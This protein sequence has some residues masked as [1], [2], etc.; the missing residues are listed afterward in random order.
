MSSILAV[1]VLVIGGGVGAFLA[2]GSSGKHAEGE[3]GLEEGA[4][5]LADA[6]VDADVEAALAGDVEELA[7]FVG[8]DGAGAVDLDRGLCL[9]AARRADGQKAKRE[10][11]ESDL[12]PGELHA[13]HP[14]LW[15]GSRATAPVLCRAVCRPTVTAM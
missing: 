7:G 8:G 14:L 4:D 12:L 15:V 6:G 13:R 9:G 3:E 2:M 1:A 10:G 11:R 5:V